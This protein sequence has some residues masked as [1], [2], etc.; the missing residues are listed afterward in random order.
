MARLTIDLLTL[1]CFGV[2]IAFFAC[3]II[4]RWAVDKISQ[5]IKK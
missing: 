4:G 3:G 1:K 2:I 5:C